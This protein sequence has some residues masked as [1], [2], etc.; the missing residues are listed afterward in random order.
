MGIS[1]LGID[2]SE[3]LV[4]VGHSAGADG[5]D[6]AIAE[7]A[8]LPLKDSS[9]DLVVSIAALHHLKIDKALAEWRRV[10]AHRGHL[11]LAEPNSLNPIAALGRK[12]FPLETHTSGEKPFSPQ[13]LREALVRNRWLIQV[14]DS[15]IVLSFAVSR[16]L[17]LLEASDNVS[18]TFAK[19]LN[20]LESLA[21]RIPLA[22]KLGWILLCVAEKG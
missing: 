18:R 19:L 4:R 1:T 15:Q 14:W 7:A 6:F 21:D 11:L 9:V 10:T 20:P 17:K 2:V 8:T 16:M 22:R 12:F 3:N 13:E 5:A